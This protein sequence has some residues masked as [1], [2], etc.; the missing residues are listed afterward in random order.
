DVY[1]RQVMTNAENRLNNLKQLASKI[2]TATDPKA[3]QDLT[4][5]IN[6]EQAAIQNEQTRL[7]LF[8][9]MAEIQ[10]KHAERAERSSRYEQLR[11]AAKNQ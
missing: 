2:N 11:E 8:M 3:I 4:A 6:I 10:E 9:K 7:Q 1:K 5:R